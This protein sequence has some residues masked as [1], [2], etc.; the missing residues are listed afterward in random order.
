MALEFKASNPD[1]AAMVR[2]SFGRQGLMTTLGARI[3]T[4][5]PG[6]CVIEMPYAPAVSQQQ[7]YF[8]GGAIG[9]IA[10]T[11]AGYAAYSLMPADAE[12]LTVEYKLN[13]I[14]AAL[15]PML[16]AE[17]RVLRAGKTLTVCRADVYHRGA[18]DLESC[19]LLQS[20]LMRVE[21]AD[22]AASIPGKAEGFTA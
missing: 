12:I 21:P 4:I 13:L 16:R 9:A 11:A 14:R 5:E 20:T 15:P 6:V 17:G 2:A 8:H 1:F 19:A 10:D 3:V 18:N 7:G 22:A